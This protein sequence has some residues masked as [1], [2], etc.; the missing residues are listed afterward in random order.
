VRLRSVWVRVS[1]SVALAGWCVALHGQSAPTA[2]E[3]I[4]REQVRQ[5]VVDALELYQAPA[6]EGEEKNANL[7]AAVAD[8]VEVGPETV[9]FLVNE[10]E[11]E[12]PNTFF[13]TSYALGRLGTPEA[14]A[15]LRAAVAAAEQQE[16]D[17]PVMRKAWSC[18]ALGMAGVD[19]AVDLLLDGRHQ[20]A[21]QPIH[22]SMTVLEAIA[23]FTAPDSIESLQRHLAR[24]DDE[25]DPRYVMRVAILKAVERVAS[26]RSTEFAVGLLEDSPP[27]VRRQAAYVLGAIDTP[28][29]VTALLSAIEDPD[30]RVRRGVALALKRA[31]P[32]SRLDPLVEW[33]KS[34]ERPV[35]RGAL[36][37]SIARAGGPD[38]TDTLL[39]YWGRED[40][41]DRMQ[42]VRA[43]RYL[44]L[45]KVKPTLIEALADPQAGVS[46]AA[47]EILAWIG[48]EPS[49]RALTEMVS[50]PFWAHAQSALLELQRHDVRAA[51]E[52]IADRLVDIELAGVV[53]DPRRRLH[54]EMLSEALVTLEQA[55]RLDDLRVAA[56]RQTD[57]LLVQQLERAIRRL[58]IIRSNGTKTKLWLASL[59]SPDPEA[60]TLAYAHFCH[61]PDKRAATLLTSAFGRVSP[62]EGRE[63]L[64]AL[65]SHDMPAARDLLDRVL[66]GP[67]FDAYEFR[68][69]REMAGWSARRI[70]GSMIDSLTESVER[71]DGQDTAVL[72]YLAL[73][74]GRDTIPY[75]DR[76]RTER[77]RYIKWTRAEEMD[78][79][80]WLR[81]ELEAG[82]P[83]FEFDVPP[84]RL[85]F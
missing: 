85:P 21:T 22:A 57:A 47:A 32:T 7:V 10:L 63:I 45:D 55:S 48:D 74:G 77:L 68:S 39:A 34:E 37:D 67:E 72:L 1:A 38:Y 42:L 56:E 35:V 43:M 79:L 44:D 51:G 64:R 62:E 46:I 40:P 30:L 53:T 71:R 76:Y 80:D 18:W 78:K 6:E 83:V 9:P 25:N 11:A 70:G 58:E 24:Y 33:L 59:E 50:S 66:V 2:E 52:A 69:L 75:V 82:R 3:L 36:Y 73:A 29:A 12:Q 84:D 4:R 15:A 28:E 27:A 19:D 61:R 49:V 20:A 16:G 13:F 41:R 23:L 14:V 8:L 60:R 17:W 26:P 31:L 81:D 54:I 65:G 5:A